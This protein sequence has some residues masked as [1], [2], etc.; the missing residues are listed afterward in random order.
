MAVAETFDDLVGAAR[1]ARDKGEPAEAEA[2]YRRAATFAESQ[3]LPV[4]LAFAR[5]HISDL[6]RLRGAPNEA[7]DTA[8][9]AAEAYRRV[10][11]ART[12]DLANALRLTALALT[13]LA[14]ME[15]ARS[16]WREA[17]VLYEACGVQA[18]VDE[19]AARLK[20]TD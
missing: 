14:R 5:R 6:A 11:V 17:G 15:E 19:C 12:L 1:A 18:G 9:A 20:P 7:L 8:Q 2:L 16:A 4:A 13:D 3:G 10:V